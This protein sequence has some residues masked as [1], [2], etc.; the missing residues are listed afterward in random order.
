MT[1]HETDGVDG[2]PPGFLELPGIVYRDDPSWIPEDPH[3]LAAA[4]SAGNPYFERSR[5]RAVC[6]PGKARA[7]AFFDPELRIDNEPV[8]YAGYFESVGDGDAHAE[9]LGRVERWAREQ[10]AAVLYGPIQFNTAH[11]Y[12]FR[13]SGPSDFAPFLGEPYNPDSYPRYWEEQG[14]QLARRYSSQLIP[15]QKLHQALTI[16]Q[17]LRE[18]LLAE[19]YRF[20][21]PTVESWLRHLPTIHEM[22]D[23]IFSQNFAYSRRSYAAF[24][25]LLEPAILHKI[26]QQSSIL[27]Y[28]PDGSLA[29]LGLS[30]PHYGP[31]L[32]QGRGSARI[33]SRDIDYHQHA[34]LL[35]EQQPRGCIGKTLGVHPAHRRKGI[36]EVLLLTG[37]ERS[38]STYDIWCAATMREDN[39][40]RRVFSQV[41]ISEHWYALYSKRL[42]GAK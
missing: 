10:G 13:L 23:A 4:F 29:A 8:A 21:C 27:V 31:L 1:I 12:R 16:F 17:P 33:L 41:A 11:S 6:I 22:V 18:A 9:V 30:Y 37:F 19:G 20:E 25:A 28:A 14:F 26:C 2:L 5:A 42:E 7:V 39:P 24:A 40:S 36:K 15:M 38:L 3:S 34:P 32:V 35:A